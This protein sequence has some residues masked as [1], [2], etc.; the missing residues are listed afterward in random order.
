MN[1]R[2]ERKKRRSRIRII[3]Y[4]VLILAIAGLTLY[5]VNR[6]NDRIRYALPDVSTPAAEDI[7]VIRIDPPESETIELERYEDGWLIQPQQYRAGSSSVQQL[8]NAIAELEITELVSTAEYYSR[9]SLDEQSRTTITAVA[10]GEEVLRFYV[11]K[12]APTYNHT[13]VLLPDDS[14]VYQAS[15]NIERTFDKDVDDLRDKTVLSMEASSITRISAGMDG[16]IVTLSRKEEQLEE[17]VQTVWL[18]QNGE[19]WPSEAINDGLDRLS[20]LTCREYLE[21]EAALGAERLAVTLTGDD[22]HELRIFEEGDNGYPATSSQSA[23]P[24]VLSSYVAEEIIETFESG[25]EG[26]GAES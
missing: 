5:I 9:Y 24:F 23:Y 22:E 12:R 10:D 18:D 21:K 14:R 3:T 25:P 20:S 15:G 8:V 6:R 16:K 2:Q 1:N 26:D 17:E 13:Y 19:E 11:G 4:G 7:D